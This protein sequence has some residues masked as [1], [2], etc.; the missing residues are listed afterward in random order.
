MTCRVCHCAFDPMVETKSRHPFFWFA[1]KSCVKKARGKA[2]W[3]KKRKR[4]SGSFS[5]TD[6]LVTLLEHEFKCAECGKHE[7]SL[8]LDHIV[9]LGEG[10]RNQYTNMQP[11]CLK[12]SVMKSRE[13]NIR[14]RQKLFE[15]RANNE[16]SGP[17]NPIKFSGGTRSPRSEEALSCLS[18]SDQDS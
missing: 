8:T 14:F 12:C 13:E 15:E 3:H 17:F 9:S 1:C 5:L 16:K 6:W 2:K 10:G 4:G 18:E 7:P 11:L